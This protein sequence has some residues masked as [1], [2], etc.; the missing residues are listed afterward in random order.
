MR[1]GGASACGPPPSLMTLQVRHAAL[2]ERRRF[3]SGLCGCTALQRL[4]V[5]R[6]WHR[7]VGRSVACL[8]IHSG[9]PKLLA[10]FL[11]AAEVDD[12]EDED[13]LEASCGLAG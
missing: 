3:T 2:A 11:S 12:D 9:D 5:Q 6:C 4:A 8:V 1:A 7:L 10:F 13:D